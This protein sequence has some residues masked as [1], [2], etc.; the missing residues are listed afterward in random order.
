MT[1]HQLI[2][3]YSADVDAIAGAVV[4]QRD[5]AGH[6]PAELD[7]ALIEYAQ[8]AA[9]WDRLDADTLRILGM[10]PRGDLET[11]DDPD[12]DPDD[13]G[14]A[15]D[16]LRE[17]AEFCASYLADSGRF[18]V[19]ND[20]GVTVY[21]ASQLTPRQRRIV[22]EGE[23]YDPYHDAPDADADY[24]DAPGSET[25]GARPLRALV[26]LSEDDE[27]AHDIAEVVAGTLAA[28]ELPGVAAD[29]RPVTVRI[30]LDRRDA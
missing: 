15:A 6:T 7:A 28:V 14:R 26:H 23:G 8:A 16:G 24:A 12:S 17:D 5:E 18:L 19:D 11:I 10:D 29:G 27:R 30:V 22:A 25:E 4:F 13:V 20:G 21:D 3:R 1:P 2:A 9:E